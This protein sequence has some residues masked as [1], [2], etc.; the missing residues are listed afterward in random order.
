MNFEPTDQDIVVN[1]DELRG[2]ASQLYQEAG[3]PKSG[4]RCCRP[5]A[6]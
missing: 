1:A 2:F 6:G 3:V 5:F 4:C